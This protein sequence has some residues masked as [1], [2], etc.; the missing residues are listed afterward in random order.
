MGGE[1]RLSDFAVEQVQDWELFS[2]RVEL[3]VIAGAEH[4]F[5]RQQAPELAA[6]LTEQVA[7]WREPVAPSGTP[8]DAIGRAYAAVPQPARRL[9]PRRRSA[10]WSP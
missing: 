7:R 5:N 6:T 4:F 2:D 3:D 8:D 1:D 10:S 9:R